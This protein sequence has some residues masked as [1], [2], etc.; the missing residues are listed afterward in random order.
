MSSGRRLA[1]FDIDG[2]LLDSQDNILLAAR[3]V[4]ERHGLPQPS[5]DMILGATGLSLSEAVQHLSAGQDNA[6]K[7]RIIDD[8][9]AIFT[10][11]RRQP[12][13]PERLYSGAVE[14]LDALKRAGWQLAVATANTRENTALILDAHGLCGYFASV[15][16]ADGNASKPN[17]DMLIRAMADLGAG[18]DQAVMIGDSSFDMIMAGAAGVRAIGVAW[19]Y[20][21]AEDLLKAGASFV[22]ENFAALRNH[23]LV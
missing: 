19:G 1:I 10:A 11:F 6:L 4:C 14:T 8:Y 13:T 5:P 12:V 21:K 20:Q 16:T 18:A 3:Q 23:L 22:A 17:P 2:T 15:Q 7:Q 9:L